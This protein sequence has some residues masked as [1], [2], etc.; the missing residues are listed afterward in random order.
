LLYES[1]SVFC[2]DDRLDSLELLQTEDVLID[3]TRPLYLNFTPQV[4][5]ER[6]RDFYTN[7]GDIETVE[8]EV[9]I[10]VQ[11]PPPLQETE[12]EPNF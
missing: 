12:Y 3:W 9:Y 11:E 10:S 2:P 6:L 4:I 7:I 5:L 1:F 8:G